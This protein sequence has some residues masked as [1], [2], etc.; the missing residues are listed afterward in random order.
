MIAPEF[1][2]NVFSIHM[3]LKFHITENFLATVVQQGDHL[4]SLLF[5][6]TIQ[7]VLDYMNS[8]LIIGYLDDITLDSSVQTVNGHSTVIRTEANS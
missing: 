7:P 1:C 4:G 8:E 5:C 6:F 3:M 2:K